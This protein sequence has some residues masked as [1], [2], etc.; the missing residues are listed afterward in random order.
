MLNTFSPTQT[1]TQVKTRLYGAWITQKGNMINVTE[2]DGH[3][4][5]AMEYLYPNTKKITSEQANTFYKDMFERGFLRLTYTRKGYTIEKGQNQI[6]KMS[7]LSY[8]ENAE[9]VDVYYHR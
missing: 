9:S 6:I 8:V 2:Y 5:Y 3:F 1:N 7:Q 4:K